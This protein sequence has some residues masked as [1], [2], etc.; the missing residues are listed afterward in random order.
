[1]STRM[2]RFP[3]VLLALIFSGAL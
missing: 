1:M 2:A 3:M